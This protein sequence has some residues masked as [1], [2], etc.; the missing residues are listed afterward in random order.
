VNEDFNNLPAVVLQLME[1]RLLYAFGEVSE[2][3]EERY[4]RTFAATTNLLS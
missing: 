3:I 1:A 2:E 4:E